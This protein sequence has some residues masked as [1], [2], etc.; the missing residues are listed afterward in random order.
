MIRTVLTHGAIA[1]LIVG[2]PLFAMMVFTGGQSL[3]EGGM[4]LGYSI[5]LIALSLVFLAIKRQRDVEGGGV[6]RFWPAVGLGLGVSL[7]AALCYVIA[8]EAAL[9]V[10]GADFI[11]L[12][13]ESLI[14]DERAKGAGPAAIA[15]LRAD[16]AAF[17]KSYA[18]PLYRIPLTM[19]EILPVGIL[20]SLVSA[21]LLR[22]PSFM[23][24]QRTGAG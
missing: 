8:W 4:L 20:V 15:K 5:M 18:D 3:I 13:T 19:T 6:I 12:Y 9:A 7:V 17:A 11:G 24:A 2:A 10:T 22:N 23:P 16:M 14:A 1:G 21:A